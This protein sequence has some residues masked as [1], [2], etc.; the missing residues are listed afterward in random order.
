[1]PR[2][3]GIPRDVILERIPQ[4]AFAELQDYLRRMLL[5]GDPTLSQHWWDEIQQY[6]ILFSR[7]GGD[8]EAIVRVGG[9]FPS[10]LATVQ[11]KLAQ[12]SAFR[13]CARKDCRLPFEITSKHK[14]RFCSQYCAHLTSLRKRRQTMRKR[15][16]NH[17]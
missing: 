12:G 13:T 14:R 16:K 4:A 1:M 7:T 2:R 3:R 11:F 17:R 5:T 6:S 10:M 9:V 15:A 8:S